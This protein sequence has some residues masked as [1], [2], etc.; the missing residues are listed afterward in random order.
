M[1]KMV[2]TSGVAFDIDIIHKNFNRI[3]NQIYKLLPMREEGQDWVKPLETLIEELSGMKRLIK[4]Q[5]QIF[6]ILLCK[7][8]GLFNLSEQEKM[9]IYRRSIFECLDLLNKI[10]KNVCNR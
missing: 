7:M 6:F 3:I 1:E 5:D 9:S 2:L 10:D 8:E 4:D